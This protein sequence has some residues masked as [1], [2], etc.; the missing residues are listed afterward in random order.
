[1]FCDGIA[2][3]SDLTNL[4]QDFDYRL[5]QKAQRKLKSPQ[6]VPEEAKER[7]KPTTATVKSSTTRP[8]VDQETESVKNNFEN[9]LPPTVCANKTGEFW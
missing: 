2:P 5:E 3:G 4:D 8:K 6:K 7:A 1:M 9:S